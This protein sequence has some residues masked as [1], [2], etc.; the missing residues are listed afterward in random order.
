MTAPA[1]FENNLA[2]VPER[3]SVDVES[4]AIEHSIPLTLE[5]VALSR[6]VTPAG[7]RFVEM[8]EAYHHLRFDQPITFVTAVRELMTS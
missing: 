1:W 4:C 3:G 6:E 8:P 2:Q 7:T 5:V